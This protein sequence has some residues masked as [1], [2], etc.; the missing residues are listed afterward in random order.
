M[1]SGVLVL[2]M[3]GISSR[4]PRGSVHRNGRRQNCAGL[5]SAIMGGLFSSPVQPVT[6]RHP[7]ALKARWTGLSAQSIASLH[8]LGEESRRQ[9]ARLTSTALAQRLERGAKLRGERLRL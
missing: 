5:A 2:S 1:V 9:A 4:D 8:R 7:L 6:S 3:A